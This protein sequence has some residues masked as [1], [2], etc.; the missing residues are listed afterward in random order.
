MV[1]AGCPFAFICG[2]NPL[3]LD[4]DGLPKSSSDARMDETDKIEQWDRELAPFWIEIGSYFRE[5][6]KRRGAKY[7]RKDCEIRQIRSDHFVIYSYPKELD[8][9]S[10]AIRQKYNL[11]QID[12]PLC[13]GRVPKPY[14]QP[15][16]FAALPGKI[17]YLSLG[18]LFSAYTYNLQKIVDILEKIPG[19]K[20]IVSESFVN[21]F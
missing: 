5:L 3:V 14:E 7:E 15:A 19:Y 16:G 8:Y 1:N 20:Y 4:F 6:F 17:V 10:E 13:S 21:D 11:W 12:T 18:S 9:F 2:A